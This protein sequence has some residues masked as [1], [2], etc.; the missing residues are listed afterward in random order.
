M[1]VVF[2]CQ[3]ESSPTGRN[4]VD[5]SF[6]AV[7]VIFLLQQFRGRVNVLQ[8]L[9]VLVCSVTGNLG[10]A[11]ST[12]SLGLARLSRFGWT[13]STR[14]DRSGRRGRCQSFRHWDCSPMTTMTS[15]S[16]TLKKPGGQCW[17]RLLH[18][19]ELTVR[20]HPLA[21]S[22]VDR[23]TSFI[24]HTVYHMVTMFQLLFLVPFFM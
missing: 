3:S 2:A 12:R 13:L 7:L 8:F 21:V 23:S 15:S 18:C 1:Q 20:H 22:T 9:P 24:D 5:H 19:L 10:W 17:I 6:S 4:N 11:L 16:P 14:R